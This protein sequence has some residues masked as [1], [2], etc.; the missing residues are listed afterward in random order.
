MVSV[1]TGDEVVIVHGQAVIVSVVGAVTVIVSPFVVMVVG[2]G[3]YV[4]S[5]VTTVVVV[6]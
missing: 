4:T 2:D 1:F 3:Q 6:V 5:S